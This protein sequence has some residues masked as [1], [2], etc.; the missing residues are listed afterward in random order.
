MRKKFYCRIYNAMTIKVVTL[1]R[2]NMYSGPHVQ[3]TL[4][5]KPDKDIT[6]IVWQLNIIYYDKQ[7]LVKK[8]N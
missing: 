7:C 6:F 2:Y 8:I 4:Q 5:Q 3:F 1:V